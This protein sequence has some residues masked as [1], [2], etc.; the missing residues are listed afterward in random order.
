M[1][2]IISLI[3]FILFMC[4]LFFQI[5]V[6][7]NPVI[8]FRVYQKIGIVALEVFFLTL[9]LL[10][11][12]TI[13]HDKKERKENIRLVLWIIFLMYIGNMIFLLFF[14]KDF[15]RNIIFRNGDVF[16]QAINKINLKPMQMIRDYVSAYHHGN[17]LFAHL[18]TNLVG[19]III[20]APLG[21]LLPSLFK[22][23]NKWVN[24]ALLVAVLIITSEF[25]QYY[26]SVGVC[27]IDDFILNFSGAMV[28][29]GFL[30]IPWINRLWQRFI[31]QEK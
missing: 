23:M 2:K 31:N 17:I 25:M 21:I 22:S 24:Y 29:Y 6:A 11:S 20:F 10:T 26:L 5:Y 16:Y 14:D 27:D 3:S 18:V 28:V 19:N 8:S 1:R 7:A 12:L 13:T 30:K 4:T 15:G 9:S